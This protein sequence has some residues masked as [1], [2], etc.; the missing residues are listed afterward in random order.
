[1]GTALPGTCQAIHEAAVTVRAVSKDC[2][3]H[4]VQ[5]GYGAGSCA[6]GT[7]LREVSEGS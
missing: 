1:M 6:T 3:A 5:L 4:D 2:K 7:P